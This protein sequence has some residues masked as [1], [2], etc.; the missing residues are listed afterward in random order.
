MD[1]ILVVASHYDD[2][3]L[4]CGGTIIKHVSKG[5]EVNIVFCCVGESDHLTKEMSE[6]RKSQ[7]QM[8]AEK[9]KIKQVIILDIPLI[10]AETLPQLE[11]VRKL[12]RTLN[13]IQPQIVYTHFNDDINSDHRVISNAMSV[14]LR[15][16]KMPFIKSVYQYEVFASTKNFTPNHYVDIG[17]HMEQKLEA[18]G[19]YTTEINVQ[20]RSIET[21]RSNGRYR[22]SEV[23]LEYAEAFNVYYQIS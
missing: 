18:L 12:L 21:I 1:K 7:A 4:G 11:V 5:D 22:G 15:P 23:N 14:W 8:V 16:S 6:I 20:T 17:L 10:M 3:V 19:M 9:L 13:Q 2:E